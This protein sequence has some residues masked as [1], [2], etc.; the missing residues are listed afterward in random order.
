MATPKEISQQV[1]LER[2]QIAQ[3][4]KRLRTNTFKLESQSYASATTYGIA[5]IDCLLPIVVDHIKKTSHDRLTRGTGYQFQ[6]IKD[7]VSQLEPLA[8]AAIACKITFDRVFSHKIGSNSLV[9]V[10]EA[11]GNAIEDE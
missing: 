5:S 11:I 1:D 4:L 2:D 6:L 9:K 3:G 10:C 8:S 7:Y